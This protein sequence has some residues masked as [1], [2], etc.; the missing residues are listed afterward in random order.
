MLCT[1]C[2]LSSAWLC[3]TGRTDVLHNKQGILTLLYVNES[4]MLCF[5]PIALTQS[6]QV[7]AVAG[8]GGA[9]LLHLLGLGGLVWVLLGLLLSVP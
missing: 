1:L 8:V 6:S 5:A 3:D 2:R 4:L 9:S 7:V